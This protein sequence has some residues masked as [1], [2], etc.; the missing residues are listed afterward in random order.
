[1]PESNL[2]VANKVYHGCN[3]LKTKHCIVWLNTEL[4][5]FNFLLNFSNIQVCVSCYKSQD[6]FWLLWW[7]SF[8]W[9]KARGKKKKKM[10][11]KK[12]FVFVFRRVSLWSSLI[13]RFME[14]FSFN[15]IFLPTRLV[16]TVI[17][18]ETYDI[19]CM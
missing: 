17:E 2:E 5:I 18:I 10:L 19:Y 15:Y 13:V 8:F 6:L 4:N 14:Y 3:R 11:K 12:S 9:M 7:I 16:E 1:M